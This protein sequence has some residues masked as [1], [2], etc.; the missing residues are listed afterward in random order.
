[1]HAEARLPVVLVADSP[2]SGVGTRGDQ[3]PVG[4]TPFRVRHATD[5]GVSDIEAHVEVLGDV[6]LGSRADPPPVPVVVAAGIGHRQIATTNNTS[7]KALQQC[8]ECYWPDRYTSL[9][10]SRRGSTSSTAGSRSAHTTR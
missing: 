7:T 8:K 3:W 9:P 2:G 5:L 4:N 1:M 10:H 6:P